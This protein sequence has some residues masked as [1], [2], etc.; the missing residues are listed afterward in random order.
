MSPGS[1]FLGTLAVVVSIF[2]VYPASPCGAAL[3]AVGLLFLIYLAAKSP[4]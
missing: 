4:R 3:M 2:I 1:K